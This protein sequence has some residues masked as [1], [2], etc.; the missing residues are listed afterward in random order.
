MLR[1]QEI[2]NSL[3]KTLGEWVQRFNEKNSLSS[4]S[5]IVGSTKMLNQNNGDVFGLLD[6]CDMNQK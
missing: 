4:K 1:K 6:S 3:Y 5:A 2:I